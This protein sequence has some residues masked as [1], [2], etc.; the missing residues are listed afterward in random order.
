MRL[1]AAWP[2]SS[3]LRASALSLLDARIH[4]PDCLVTVNIRK[5]DLNW[6]RLGTRNQVEQCRISG[7][8]HDRPKRLLNLD[9]S[10][11]ISHDNRSALAQ[12]VWKDTDNLF[13]ALNILAA[14]RV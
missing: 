4:L 13:N 12:P 6:P 8:C 2:S 1:L 3:R 10:E 9:V 7:G 11:I 14:L 5:L